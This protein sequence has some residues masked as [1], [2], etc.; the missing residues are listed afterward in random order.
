MHTIKVSRTK[1]IEKLAINRSKHVSTF[2]KAKKGFKLKLIERLKTML[3]K[4]RAGKGDKALS[5]GLTPPQNF[6]HEYDRAL[7]ML[8]M[9]VEK[10]I[11]LTQEEFVQYV[12]DKWTW[13]Q[14]AFTNTVYAGA[15]RKKR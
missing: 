15:L 14:H 3:A 7:S 1:L 4:A 8:K 9:S 6:S 2:E 10:E 5:V 13:S 12:E 11:E